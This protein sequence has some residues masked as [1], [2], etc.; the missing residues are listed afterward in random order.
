MNVCR[1]Y[2]ESLVEA[3]GPLPTQYAEANQWANDLYAR[4]DAGEINADSIDELRQIFSPAHSSITMHGMAHLKPHGYHGDYEIIDRH[5][6]QAVC[7]NPQ[8]R[9]WDLLWH[10]GAAAQAVRNRP[11]YLRD[12]IARHISNDKPGPDH[13]RSGQPWC[14]KVRW[15]TEH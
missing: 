15:A 7:Q 14:A 12:V 4:V 8:F 6:T 2:L 5:Y 11:N 3:G 10:W 13:M 9:Q 1:A